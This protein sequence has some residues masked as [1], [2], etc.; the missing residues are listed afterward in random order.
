[1]LCCDLTQLPSLVAIRLFLVLG[2][3]NPPWDPRLKQY[4][5]QIDCREC[6]ANNNFGGGNGSKILILVRIAS[7]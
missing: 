6:L 5:S 4:L 1:M 2:I 3:N 7:T